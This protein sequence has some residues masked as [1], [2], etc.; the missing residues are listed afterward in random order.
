MKDR[1]G[2]SLVRVNG[3]LRY[4][5]LLLFLRNVINRY[6]SVSDIYI[7]GMGNNELHFKLFIKTTVWLYT[8]TNTMYSFIDMV[9]SVYY[10]CN[11]NSVTDKV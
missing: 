3:I 8:S 7:L 5:S 11:E 10:N 9:M 1:N 6:L 4:V 2:K